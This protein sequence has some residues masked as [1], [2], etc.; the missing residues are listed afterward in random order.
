MV[1]PTIESFEDVYPSDAKTVQSKRWNKLLA[2]FEKQYGNKAEFVSRSPGRVNI[3]GEVYNL[4]S[5]Y[6]SPTPPRRM[7]H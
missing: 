6:T 3:I 4:F 2:S 1:V 5:T 7:E